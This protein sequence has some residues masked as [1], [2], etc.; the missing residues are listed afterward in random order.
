MDANSK[1]ADTDNAFVDCDLLIVGAGPVGLFGTYYA[2]FRGLRVAVLDALQ[3]PGGQ[4]SA[5]YP[6]KLIFDIAGFPAVKG[7]DLVEGLVQQAER[8]KPRYLLGDRAQLLRPLTGPDGRTEFEVI[9]ANGVLVRC[10]AVVVTAGIG[11]FAPRKLGTGEEFEGRGL[12]YFV[13]DPADYSDHDV[14][15]VGGGDSAVDWALTLHPIARSVTLVHRR[16]T[17]RAHE[18]SLADLRAT[19]VEIVTDAQ[20]A[21]VTGGPGIERVALTGPGI[22]GGRREL[23]CQRLVATLGFVADLGPLRS[24]GLET[25]HQ[26][27]VIVDSAMQTSVPGV[28]AAGDITDYPGKVRLIAV[29]FGEAATAVNNAAVFLNPEAELFPGHSTDAE[30]TVAKVAAGKG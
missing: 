29:G 17:F 26:R 10:G 19:S 25:A 24:W 3:E 7:R 13:P 27:H 11:A 1:D 18:A 14:V 8:F 9:T 16:Q 2:G 5:M 20:V 12:A 4:I 6:E 21:E 15:V 23:P 30:S 22:E 28:Y